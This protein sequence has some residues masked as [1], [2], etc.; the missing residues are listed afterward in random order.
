MGLPPRHRLR[1][2]ERIRRVGRHGRRVTQRLGTWCMLPGETEASRLCAVFPR[3]LGSA[4]ARNRARRRLQEAFRQTA[5]PGQPAWDLVFRAAPPAIGGE[6]DEFATAL[7]E[8]LARAG[9]QG[10][11]DEPGRRG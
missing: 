3:K 10:H 7:T 2:R 4:V 6:R 11:D 1:G 9:G 8:L 5:A